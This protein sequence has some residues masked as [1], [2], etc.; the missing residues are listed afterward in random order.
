MRIKEILRSKGLTAK[1]AAQRAG[2][3]EAAFSNI[4]NEKANPSLST[5]QKIAE[6]L[7]VDISELFAERSSSVISA[8]PH[9]GSPVS[10]HVEL[11]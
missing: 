1:E 11:K 4:A 3:A 5:L 9:C 6:A 10:V 8:C 2:I 7:A